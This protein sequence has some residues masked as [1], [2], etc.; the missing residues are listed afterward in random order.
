MKVRKIVDFFFFLK[1]MKETSCRLRSDFVLRD[2]LNPGVAWNGVDSHVKALLFI[3][4]LDDYP[5]SINAID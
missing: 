3:E 5:K 4:N 2:L 1:G